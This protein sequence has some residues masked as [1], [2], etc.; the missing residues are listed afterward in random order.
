MYLTRRISSGTEWKTSCYIPFQRPLS[1]KN[2]S[3]LEDIK[4]DGWQSIKCIAQEAW[5]ACRGEREWRER[6]SEI[7]GRDTIRLYRGEA[8]GG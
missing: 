6:L 3:D 2:P 8:E 4:E 5:V 7:V 1:Q